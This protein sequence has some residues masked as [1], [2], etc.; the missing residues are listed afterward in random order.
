MLLS[1]LS[2][3]NR[4]YYIVVV[5]LSS[6][7]GLRYYAHMY[8]IRYMYMHIIMR[9]AY[10]IRNAFLA[11]AA[12]PEAATTDHR[13]LHNGRLH[14]NNGTPPHSHT[15]RDTRRILYIIYMYV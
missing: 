1:R 6:M 7:Y 3:D 9:C 8:F 4:G 10:L 12:A 11:A 5:A 2:T 15:H 14:G 13:R